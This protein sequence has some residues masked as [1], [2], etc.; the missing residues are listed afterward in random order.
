[1]GT[2][3]ERALVTG[4]TGL[5]GS[6]VVM[7]LLDRGSSEVNAL[8]RDARRAAELLPTDERVRVMAGDV[9]DVGTFRDRLQGVDAIFHTAA[10]FREYYQTDYDPELLHRTNVDSVGTLLAAAVDGG[11]PVVV[12]TS[13][14]TTI[15]PATDGKPADEDTPPARNWEANVYR[16]SKV[17]SERVVRAF[18][19]RHRLRVPIVLPGWIW[20]PGDA[21]PTPAGRLFLAIARG[22]MR[23]VPRA[24]NHVVDARDVAA[25]CVRAAAVGESGRRYI[26]AGRYHELPEL[27][28]AVARATGGAAPRSVPAFAARLFATVMERQAKLRGRRPLITRSGVQALLDGGRPI[29]SER[30]QRELGVVFRPLEQT[31]LDEAAWYRKQGMLPD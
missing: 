23:A 3:P 26:V 30:A 9:N 13:S 6:N 5:L 2:V 20:G 21:G 17:R 16:A 29:S 7:E 22:E 1:M 15:G 28:A 12:H 18:L 25:A 19:E 11:V 27:C 10:Y 31:M 8:V 24:G 14:I 4:A